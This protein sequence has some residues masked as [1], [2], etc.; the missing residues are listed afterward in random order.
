MHSAKKAS[1]EVMRWYT[2]IRLHAFS[3]LTGEDVSPKLNAEWRIVTDS[4][5][6]S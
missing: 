6:G 4:F 5:K 2:I 1:C 3:R